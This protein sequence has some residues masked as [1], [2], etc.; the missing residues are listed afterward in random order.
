M[1]KNKNNNSITNSLSI[2]FKSSIFI[3]KRNLAIKNNKK[4]TFEK[5]F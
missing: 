5:F 3:H 4:K 2:S 1:K